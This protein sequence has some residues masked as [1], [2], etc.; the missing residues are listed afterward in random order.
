MLFIFPIVFT[1]YILPKIFINFNQNQTTMHFCLSGLNQF[2]YLNVLLIFLS[3]FSVL[4]HFWKGDKSNKPFLLFESDAT[5]HFDRENLPR[6]AQFFIGFKKVLHT[7]CDEETD[8]FFPVSWNTFH[9]GIRWHV[10]VMEQVVKV[11]TIL[12]E[13]IYLPSIICT[14][15]SKAN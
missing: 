10:Y 8:W 14:T 2:L 7:S 1:D 4:T 11:M 12:N 9:M 3:A 13:W 6:K 5:F 15:R